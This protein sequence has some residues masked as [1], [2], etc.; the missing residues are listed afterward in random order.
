MEHS[1]KNERR[2][3]I[4]VLMFPWLAYGHITPYLE[5]AKKLVTKNSSFI[6]YIYSTPATFTCIDKKVPQ[7][8]SNS[9]KLVP[10]HL[11]NTLELPSHLHTTRGLASH[12]IPKLEDALNSSANQFSDILEK[13]A[14]DLLIYD[15]FQSWAALLARDRNIRAVEFMTSGATSVGHLYHLL[16]RR[17][18][19]FPFPNIYQNGVEDDKRFVEI[20]SSVEKTNAML[21]G[22]RVSN[23][24]VLIKGCREIEGKY[25]DYLSS[26]MGKKFVPVGPLV[27][28]ESSSNPNDGKDDEIMA[29]LA[30]REKKSTVFVSFG[31]ECFITKEDIH[32]VAYGLELSKCNFIW[33]LRLPKGG[34]NTN[35]S[36][37]EEMLPI[38]FLDRANGRGRVL[39]GWAPQ[40]KILGHASVGGFVSHCGW[41]SL[42]ESMYFGV[43][44][45]AMP[46]HVDQPINAR[47]VEDVGVGVEVLRDKNKRF[48]REAVAEV[49]RRVVVEGSGKFVRKRAADVGAKLRGKRGDEEIDEVVKELV[50]LCMQ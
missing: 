1:N 11:P 47:L 19:E 29:W 48:R 27:A 45:I 6:V 44:V 16:L 41:N 12:L 46:M 18:T 4:R 49:I 39:E 50:G 7:N 3:T 43:P 40:T 42:M 21:E 33:V 15:C 23:K 24:I 22:A 36:S 17:G 10:F 32:E 13:L 28:L 31:S 2:G 35:V 38:G 26:L 25:I 20:I 5:L 9:I 8:L 34:D 37:I 14:P 30:E